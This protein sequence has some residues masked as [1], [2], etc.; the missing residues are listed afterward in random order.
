MKRFRLNY[1]IPDS[2]I[3][4]AMDAEEAGC[5]AP[6]DCEGLTVTYIGEDVED[7]GLDDG[8]E[9]DEYGSWLA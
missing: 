8:K 3:V 1:L 5:M 9:Q 7:F 2:V 4:T 6:M